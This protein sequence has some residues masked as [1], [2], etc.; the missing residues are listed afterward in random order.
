MMTR[1]LQEL[2]VV[3]LTEDTPEGLVEGAR[4]VIVGMHSDICT[5]EFVGPDGYTIGLFELPKSILEWVDPLMRYET[6]AR[7]D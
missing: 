7:E 5:V 1:E 2:D 6:V 3:E 4:G